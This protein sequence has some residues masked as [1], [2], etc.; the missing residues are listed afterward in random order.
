MQH[1]AKV[2]CISAIYGPR[3]FA[4]L[5]REHNIGS[6]VPVLLSTERPRCSLVALGEVDED[7]PAGRTLKD[8]QVEG[9]HSSGWGWAWGWGW[10]WG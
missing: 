4:R 8:Y 3:P 7:D 10:G 1:V 2:L 6:G 5:R 9:G